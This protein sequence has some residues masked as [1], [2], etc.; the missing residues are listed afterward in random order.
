M[1]MIIY[2]MLVVLFF[3]SSA[4][5]ATVNMTNI[6]NERYGRFLHFLGFWSKNSINDHQNS[7][8]RFNFGLGPAVSM[9]KLVNL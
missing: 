7:G 9:C 4:K 8:F 2:E 1:K 5:S 6:V 3:C